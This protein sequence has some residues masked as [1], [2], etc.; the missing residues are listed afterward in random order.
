MRKLANPNVALAVLAVLGAIVGVVWLAQPLS[1]L[2]AFLPAQTHTNL[3]LCQHLVVHGTSPSD[4][5]FQPLFVGVF[6]ALAW[7]FGFFETQESG[8]ALRAMMALSL[9][10]HLATLFVALPILRQLGGAAAMWCFGLIWVIAP[11]FVLA[12]TNGLETSLAAL[13][14][15]G[16][17]RLN[18]QHPILDC[19]PEY[20]LYQGTMMGLCILA[21]FD[22]SLIL[23]YY[24]WTIARHMGKRPPRVLAQAAIMLVVPMVWQLSPFLVFRHAEVGWRFLDVTQWFDGVLHMS[25]SSALGLYPLLV[26]ALIMAS[27]LVGRVVSPQT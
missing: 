22:L 26:I 13:L 10:F 25:P 19:R 14:F 9:V 3:A 23:V 4:G 27:L 5:V 8:V 11:P 6:S 18:L 17:W 2:L 16:I 1:T 20:Q 21:R 24:L 15:L 7:T 12:G